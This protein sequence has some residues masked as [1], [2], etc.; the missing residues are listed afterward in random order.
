MSSAKVEP[1][2]SASKP[3][4]KIIA[5]HGLNY[6]THWIRGNIKER[7]CSVFVESQLKQSSQGERVC[8]CGLAYAD[9]AEGITEAGPD[10]LKYIPFAHSKST[11]TRAFGDIDFVE[12]GGHFKKYVRLDVDTSPKDVVYLLTDVWELGKPRVLLSIAG[13]AK[14]FRLS[15]HLRDAF[16]QGLMR[17]VHTTDSWI[18]TSGFQTGVN[19][20]VGE[21][22][23]DYGIMTS[24]EKSLVTVGI[25]P[26]GCIQSADTLVNKKST[27]GLYPAKYRQVKSRKRVPL[28]PNHTHFLLVDDGTNLKYGVDIEFRSKL[29]TLI[30]ETKTDDYCMNVQNVTI[31][32]EGGPQ[33][34][35]SMLSQL[36][37]GRPVV[38]VKG[39]GRATDLVTYAYENA[40]EDHTDPNKTIRCMDESVVSTLKSMIGY[41][42]GEK[43]LERS[44]NCI[45]E[46]LAYFNLIT[47][48]DVENA[49][50][51]RELDVAIA[52]AI[53][54]AQPEVVTRFKF[55][56]IMDK[57]DLMEDDVYSRENWLDNWDQLDEVL[58]M[59]IE[60]NRVE[61]VKLFLD[62]G[63]NMGDRLTRDKLFRLYKNKPDGLLK[64]MLTSCKKDDG[65][66]GISLDDVEKLIRELSG[67]KFDVLGPYLDNPPR[68][69]FEGEWVD[70]FLPVEN[71]PYLHL[72]LWSVLLDR[73]ELAKLF[74]TNEEGPTLSA[75]VAQTILRSM[76]ERT[77]DGQL[78]ATIA[79]HIEEW[80]LIANG[81]LNLAF[82]SNVERTQGVLLAYN[83]LYGFDNCMSY[84][85]RKENKDFLAQPAAQMVLNGM[86]RGN[87]KI[88]TPLW[89]IFLC[90]LCPFLMFPLL[91]FDKVVNYRDK[92][93]MN[94]R[95][96]REKEGSSTLKRKKGVSPLEKI[97][98]FFSSPVVIFLYNVLSYIAFL[99]LYA[100]ILV[101][102]FNADVSNAEIVLIVWGVSLLTEE[103][104]QI[105]MRPSSAYLDKVKSHYTDV[106]NVTDTMVI[107]MFFIGVILRLVPRNDDTLDAARVVLA[108]TFVGFFLR[109]LHICSIHKQLGPKM[110][111]IGNMI[112]D[113]LYFLVILMVF[114]ISYAVAAQSILYPNSPL[115]WRTARQLVSKSYWNIYGELGLEEFEGEGCTDDRAVWI[116]GSQPRCP[117]DLGK[118][119]VPILL[120]IY[121]IIANVLLLNLLI[122]MFSYT[123][124]KVQDN[125]D[126]H[127]CYQRCLL[128]E[129]F[130][131]KPIYVP[132]LI[133]LS[134]LK[135]LL[136]YFLSGCCDGSCLWG[137]YTNRFDWP[138]HRPYY[139]DV[140]RW[141]SMIAEAYQQQTLQQEAESAQG[142]VKQTNTTL[143]EVL[144]RL[145]ELKQNSQAAEQKIKDMELKMSYLVT[146]DKYHAIGQDSYQ[147][148]RKSDAAIT[149]GILSSE[150]QNENACD[151]LAETSNTSETIPDK[152]NADRTETRVVGIASC[153]PG[154]SI[155]R[156]PVP[157]EKIK[158]QEP[159]EDYNPETYNA[160]DS[161]PG[162][163]AEP[164]LDKMQLDERRKALS[165]NEYDAKFGVNRTSAVGSIEVRDGFPLNPMGRTGIRG[166]GVFSRW[167]PNHF[168]RSIVTRWKLLDNGA[169]ET[170]NGKPVL[171]VL[172][173]SGSGRH[174]LPE[175][176]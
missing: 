144:H 70:D 123:F 110:V 88:D 24:L 115:S 80:S 18:F 141:E 61:A 19:Q 162:S 56:L 132:P 113:L 41:E 34:L 45:T 27:S 74:S 10:T 139:R 65:R 23:R 62:R 11:P 114:V 22:V 138:G 145:K 64:T 13:G 82:S 15:K 111:M 73:Q 66:E 122:A 87:I 106:W 48:F 40:T 57:L 118:I 36:E 170:V 33:S 79:R 84:A 167:G 140:S 25:A 120:G 28:D 133:I 78:K 5:L 117:T 108:V 90:V 97:E 134:H 46:C 37:S 77:S 174:C 116:N 151:Q 89:L 49:N 12:Y 159:F 163:D 153:Y 100:Y 71:K 102:D 137:P 105:L 69:M 9:H 1:L 91:T 157:D 173:V 112:V 6:E 147:K 38:V 127:W 4:H 68:H 43:Q 109:L 99:C 154:T 130:S 76:L 17:F 129:E 58:L 52:H 124:S 86:W 42:Y 119:V 94:I 3:F 121:M 85:L 125:T 55:A 21:A 146:S 39:T 128:V 81:V 131:N 44:F 169:T 75:L 149:I 107:V 14:F 50:G 96:I 160:V 20:Y 152:S 60:L 126:R 158:W 101:V 92:Q 31:L 155:T 165:F 104:R 30:S 59:A 29:E 16:C 175:I 26:W 83:Y 8:Q 67:D 136:K 161:L 171:E 98:S 95:K 53:L 35:M 63:I 93:R 148:K 172:V 7:E 135:L 150:R 156:F 72:F 54:K 176:F 47:I 32:M 2:T 51:H 143:E 166:R 164:D 168:S 103:I 142:R